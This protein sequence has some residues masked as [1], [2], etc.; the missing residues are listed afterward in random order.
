MP[1][2]LLLVAHP[3]DEFF[4][5]GALAAMQAS[6]VSV[7]AALWTRGEGGY[8]GTFGWLWP[9]LPAT[10]Q[11]RVREAGNSMRTLGISDW[12]FLGYRD[13]R[14]QTSPRAPDYD[15]AGFRSEIRKLIAREKPELVLTHGSNG[16]YG[17]PAH[18]A[19]H[20]SILAALAERKEAPAVITFCAARPSPD[21]K[22][23]QNISDP[24]DLVLDTQVFARQKFSVMEAHASQ[25][26]VWPQLVPEAGGSLTK[27]VELFR[28]EYYHCVKAR[29]WEK[30]RE[31]F[32]AWTGAEKVG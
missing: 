14:P 30:A 20:Q 29:Q 31:R 4:C 32:C 19:L 12:G 7:T 16:E 3:D 23:F 25:R 2:V 17:H 27:I 10:L 21:L 28:H 24:A 6:G 5:S 18:V 22:G 1:G 8:P 15:P 11:P 13:P 9:L 26:Q